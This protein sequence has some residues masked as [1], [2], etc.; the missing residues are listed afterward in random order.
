MITLPA[1]IWFEPSGAGVHTMHMAQ[2]VHPAPGRRSAVLPALPEY[3]NN[4]NNE[5]DKA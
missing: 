1:T 3:Q 5:E 4:E 2:L